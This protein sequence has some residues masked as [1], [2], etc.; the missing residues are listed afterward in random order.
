MSKILIIHKS[1]ETI[2]VCRP[3][4]IIDIISIIDPKM[5][6]MSIIHK[7]AVFISAIE[8]DGAVISFMI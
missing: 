6:K 4:R 1:I 7:S 3:S 2:F 5:S 8:A